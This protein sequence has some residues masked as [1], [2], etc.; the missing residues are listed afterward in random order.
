MN[1]TIYICQGKTCKYNGSSELIKFLKQKQFDHIEI[2]TQYCFGK[3]GN[4]CVVFAVPEERFYIYV[5]RNNIQQIIDR[6]LEMAIIEKENQS[7]LKG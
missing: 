1:I 4:G 5:N 7:K 6:A 2:K 3:C